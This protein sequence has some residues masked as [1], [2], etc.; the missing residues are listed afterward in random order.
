MALT[1][2][3]IG[4]V[5]QVSSHSGIWTFLIF[6]LSAIYCI[7]AFYKSITL[8]R[9]LLKI[10]EI[11]RKNP[12]HRE[13]KYWIVNTDN[14][15]AAFSFLNFIFINRDFS[16]LTNVEFQ[17]IKN[18]EYIHAKQGHTF[19]ILFIE[20]IG[21]LF[22]FSPLVGYAKNKIQEIH[23]Y[24]ADEKTAGHDEMKRLY[25]QL[26]FNLASEAKVFCLS[27]GF[28]GK[29]INNRIVMVSKIRS[30][31][32][33]KLIFSLLI[34]VA[35]FL[36]LSFS[37][38]NKTTGIS[39]PIR[40]NS[41]I[42]SS[43]KT[44]LKIGKINWINNT[45]INSDEL[46]KIL[47]LKTGDEYSKEKFNNRLYNDIDAVSNIYLDKG[48]MFL[49][50][51]FAENPASE[52]AVDLTITIHEGIRYKIGKVSIKGN[53]QVSSDEIFNKISVK[54]GDWFSK[55]KIVESVRALS[56][57]VIF[58]PETI[59][60]DLIPLPKDPNSEFAVVNIEFEVTEK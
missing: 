36:L 15:I 49:N 50:I 18:H 22:W 24:I 60:P 37:Y 33:Y 38:L 26:L 4:S 48:Y 6:F 21:I 58:N 31:P 29:Q 51:E 43:L 42:N 40:R 2:K 35:A 25:A 47:G 44:P 28:S 8:F 39:A 46:N 10:R 23:E 32:R 53:L 59:K 41:G 11:I 1:P 16:N 20:L 52:G 5:K 57:M 13:G 34:P 30:L 56:R 55:T 19:D 45:V 7:G 9:N 17:R 3:T 12:K 14:E 54:Q 27:T